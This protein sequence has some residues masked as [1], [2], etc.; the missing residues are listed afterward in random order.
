MQ[1]IEMKVINGMERGTGLLFPIP[2]KSE[3]KKNKPRSSR[4]SRRRNAKNIFGSSF[5][6]RVLRGYFISYQ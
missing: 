2:N 1:S 4:S 3:P 5:F 6:L